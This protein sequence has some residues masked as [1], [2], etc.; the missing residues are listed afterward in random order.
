MSDPAEITERAGGIRKRSSDQ[1][2]NPDTTPHWHCLSLCFLPHLYLPLPRLCL[3][4]FGCWQPWHCLSFPPLLPVH[5]LMSVSRKISQTSLR[6]GLLRNRP[7]WHG[8]G[9]RG[10]ARAG[11]RWLSAEWRSLAVQRGRCLREGRISCLSFYSQK[12]VKLPLGLHL[13]ARPRD[14]MDGRGLWGKVKPDFSTQSSLSPTP[15]DRCI[16]QL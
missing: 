9:W 14:W 10:S 8:S 12:V 15:G 13:E 6:L 16:S 7:C 5:L 4:S 2:W 11:A 3:I 1:Y